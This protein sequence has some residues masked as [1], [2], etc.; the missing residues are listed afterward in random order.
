MLNYQGTVI[1]PPSEA[2]SLILQVTLGCSDNSCIFCP[3][4]KDKKFKIKSI[5]E[6]ERDIKTAYQ[7]YPDIR[8][9]FLA[10][11]DALIIPQKDLLI[12]LNKILETFP[13]V[14]RISMYAS[15]KSIELKTVEELKQLQSKK[16]SLVYVGF[17]TGDKDVYQLIRKYGSPQKNVESILKLKQAGIK[18]NVTI[19][20]GLGGQRF[21][22]Q[23][24]KN[25]ADI[26][27][28]SQ[29]EQIA[30]L[31]LMVAGNTP[32]YNMCKLKQFRLLKDFD[33]LKELKILLENLQDFKCLFFANHASNYIPISARFPKE[34]QNLIS[35]LNKIIIN[36]NKKA[37]KKDFARG[38]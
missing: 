18:S 11:G 14:I 33:V 37:L 31:T 6:I 2:N 5:E 32:L 1:R 8:K 23:H 10:D 4:Y 24:A 16:M 22:F 36:C 34:R 30:A 35:M 28:R 25:T 12:I 13:A 26:L 17:E 9:I 15:V 21:S 3:A 38:L 7:Y 20:L 27:N 29:P 19:I